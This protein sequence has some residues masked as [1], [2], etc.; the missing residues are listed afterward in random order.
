MV[1]WCLFKVFSLLLLMNKEWGHVGGWLVREVFYW[2][3]LRNRT[4][5]IAVGNSKSILV[6]ASSSLK[7]PS[8]SGCAVL[9]LVSQ[10]CLTLCDTMDCSPPGSSVHGDSPCKN[11]GMGCYDLL[12]GIFPTQGSNPGLPHCR[13]ILYHL[14]HQGSLFLD[15]RTPKSYRR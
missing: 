6:F 10:L 5:W 11:S 14:S 9:C 2:G 3:S 8:L 1:A 15:S 7:S 13:Q 4:G 12:Q